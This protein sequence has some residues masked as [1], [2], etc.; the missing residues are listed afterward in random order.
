M[1]EYHGCD[2]LP[3]GECGKWVV[4]LVWECNEG[5]FLDGGGIVMIPVRV[6]GIPLLS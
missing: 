6:V 1:I 3:V 4:E 5:S 2:H